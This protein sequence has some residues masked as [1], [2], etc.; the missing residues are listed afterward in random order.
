MKIICIGLNYMD[1]IREMNN[2]IPEVPVFFLKPDSSII[3]NNKPFFYPEFTNDLHYELEVVLKINRLGRNIS[4]KFAHR[5]FSE[6][7]LGIDFTA[8]DLQRLCK[9][10]GMPWEMSK[11]FDGAAPISEF[12]SKGKFNDLG[13]IRFRLEKNDAIVQKGTTSDLVFKFDS[14]ISYVSRFITLRTGDLIFTGTP[15]GVGPVQIGDRLK[16]YLEDELML[17]FFIK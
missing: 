11:A 4:E 3:R 10:K 7:G 6:I 15:V 16:A 17:D 5:Y 13:N 12:V 9:E 1:H 2:P 8:R 14:I